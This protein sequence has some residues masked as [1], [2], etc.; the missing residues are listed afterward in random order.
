[1]CDPIARRIDVA[2]LDS[3]ACR[4][5]THLGYGMS[6]AMAQHH[7]EAGSSNLRKRTKDQ[8]ERHVDGKEHPPLLPQPSQP[9]PQQQRQQAAA[10]EYAAGGRG[11]GVGSLVATAKE[12]ALTY[13]EDSMRRL[14]YCLDWVAYATALLQQNIADLQQLLASLQQAARAGLAAGDGA[15]AVA[16]AGALQQIVQDA[17]WRLAR[18]RREIVHTVRK[19]VGVISHYAGA[20]LPGEARRQVRAMILGLPR[21][22]AAADTTLGG[23]SAG[24]VSSSDAGTPDAAS[25]ASSPLLPTRGGPPAEMR[26]ENIEATTRR[27]LAF[28]AESSAMLGNLHAVFRHLHSNAERW[29]GP[30]PD[31]APQADVEMEAAPTGPPY[32]DPSAA[33][34]P[35]LPM[36]R[37]PR[38]LPVAA[39]PSPDLDALGTQRAESAA[40]SLVDIGEQMRRMDILTQPPQQQHYRHSLVET[41]THA[42]IG[43]HGSWS[44]GV[45][46]VLCPA[47]GWSPRGSGDEVAAHKRSR[48]RE[49]TPTRM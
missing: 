46:P 12:R 39:S 6:T 1:M 25:A 45:S 22:W 44:T 15:V 3:F 35:P 17:A 10:A 13:R 19:A 16:G 40:A 37:P 21:R 36:R 48:T 28:A 20:V 29:I 5:L 38:C 11:W 41:Q 31:T 47:G 24:S 34:P 26:P 49:P 4:Q 30:A 8:V 2:Q 7:S 43:A 42:K 33:T 23:S 27:T 18:T 14:K 9:Q 32:R